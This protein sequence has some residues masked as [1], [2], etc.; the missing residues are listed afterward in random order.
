MAESNVKDLKIYQLPD[1][2]RDK[3]QPQDDSKRDTILMQHG[4]VRSAD[5]WITND[6]PPPKPSPPSPSSS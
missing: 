6:I 4:F 3:Y 1:E 2:D 5:E